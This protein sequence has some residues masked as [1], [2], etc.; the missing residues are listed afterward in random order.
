MDKNG[1]NRNFDE[2]DELGAMMSE[3]DN[4]DDLIASESIL[5]GGESD[6]LIRSEPLPYNPDNAK[7]TEPDCPAPSGDPAADSYCRTWAESAAH[8]YAYEKALD[9]AWTDVLS[10]E[11][12]K[13]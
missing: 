4:T 1:D 3:T 2:D 8:D 9:Q 13:P 6:N 12:L 7:L 5:N 10:C 11:A